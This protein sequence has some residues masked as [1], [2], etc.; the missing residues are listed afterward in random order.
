[1]P[2]RRVHMRLPLE[3]PP[4]PPLLLL[5][6]FRSFIPAKCGNKTFPDWKGCGQLHHFVTVFWE[7]FSVNLFDKLKVSDSM[8]ESGEFSCISGAPLSIFHIS[9]LIPFISHSVDSSSSLL[10]CCG[11]LWVSDALFSVGGSFQECFPPEQL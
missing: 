10:G 5:G 11:A 1:M 9:G 3:W 8:H 4:I 2:C 6:A 7:I